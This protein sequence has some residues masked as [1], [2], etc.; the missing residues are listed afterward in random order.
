M[1]TYVCDCFWGT[2]QSF[3]HPILFFKYGCDRIFISSL[4]HKFFGCQK[5]SITSRKRL[6]AGA[7][8]LYHRR[9]QLR[10]ACG[11]NRAVSEIFGR[12]WKRLSQA[13][14]LSQPPVYIYT[15][16]WLKSTAC[17]KLFPQAV[18][19]SNRLCYLCINTPSSS[20]TRTQYLAPTFHFGVPDFSKYKGGGFDLYF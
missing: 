10:C 8:F 19:L 18:D 13:V 4:T 16:G 11:I 2:Y 1:S 7:P 20:L 15:G 17:D 5:V 12:L 3:M 9:F 14:D 6:I